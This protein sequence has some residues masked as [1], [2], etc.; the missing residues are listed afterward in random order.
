MRNNKKQIGPTRT[1]LEV[2][3]GSALLPPPSSP[4]FDSTTPPPHAASQ[5]HYLL[6][7]PA[8][9]RLLPH[10]RSLRFPRLFPHSPHL[11]RLMSKSL[12]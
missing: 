4:P 7:R 9:P 8:S 6:P 3:L 2:K 11:P 5:L 1:T 12:L 10:S